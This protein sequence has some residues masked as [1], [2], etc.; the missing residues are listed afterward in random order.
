MMPSTPSFTQM[1]ASSAVTMPL[2][3]TGTLMTLRTSSMESELRSEER[4]VGKRAEGGARPVFA[5]KHT[6]GEKTA[7]DGHTRAGITHSDVPADVELVERTAE[8]GTRHLF[9]I[10]HT[11]EEHT[12]TLEGR[13]LHVAAGAVATTTVPAQAAV[14]TS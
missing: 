6:G 4:R 8:D 13:T 3:M 1:S 5:R 9:A 11:A 12:L 2:R 10:N 14:T 7:A